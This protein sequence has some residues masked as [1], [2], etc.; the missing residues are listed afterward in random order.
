VRFL[1]VVAAILFVLAL[2]CLVAPTTLAGASWQTWLVSG[3]LSWAL[4][5]LLGGYAVPVRK[6]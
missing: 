4:D 5:Q 6:P 3:L 2:V 1:L